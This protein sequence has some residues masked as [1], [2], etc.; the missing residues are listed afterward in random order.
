MAKAV[1]WI[2]LRSVSGTPRGPRGAAGPGDLRVE[3][4]LDPQLH[5]GLWEFPDDFVKLLGRQ[6]DGSG[7]EDLGWRPA[8]DPHIQIG[9]EHAQPGLPRFEQE[10]G[11]DRERLSRLHHPLK[12]GEGREKVPS[13][14]PNMHR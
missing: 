8:P 12:L 1:R 6:C 11:E 2:M 13:L 7:R 10:M 9:A 3:F 5:G 14:N 4:L